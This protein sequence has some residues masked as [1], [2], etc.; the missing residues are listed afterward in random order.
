MNKVLILNTGGTFGMVQG[1]A[2]LTPA[3]DLESRLREQVPELEHHSFDL[4]DLHPLIDSSD[5]RAEDWFRICEMILNAQ[6]SY[7]GFVVIHGTDTLAYTASALSFAL[8]GLSQPVV[9]TG[10]QYPLG[11]EGS[12]APKNLL[13]S[14][15][16]VAQPNTAGVRVCFGGLNLQA[17]RARKVDAQDYVAFQMPNGEVSYNN[18][19]AQPVNLNYQTG[20]VALILVYPG[21]SAAVI[22]GVLHD[23]RLRAIILLSFGSGNIPTAGS[24]F[25]EALKRAHARGVLLVNMTQCLKGR[26]IQ[27]AYETGALLAELGALPGFDMTPEAAFAKLHYLFAKGT[28][29]KA[30]EAQWQQSLCG[31]LS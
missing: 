25:G 3:A 31:E 7:T 16:L 9:V 14:L 24:D 2:G 21:I 22:D 5:L 11:A 26:V 23:D 18:E 15:K 30:I 29:K 19:A 28:D 6:H 4:I 10:S 27:G 1:E 17:N 12:D 20:A 8:R 13:D